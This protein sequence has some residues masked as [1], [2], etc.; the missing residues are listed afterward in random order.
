MVEEFYFLDVVITGIFK[1]CEQMDGCTD[2]LAVRTLCF[3]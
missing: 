3:A 2:R 1:T